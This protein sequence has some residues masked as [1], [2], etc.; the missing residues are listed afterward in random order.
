M[1]VE[2]LS[3]WGDLTQEDTNRLGVFRPERVMA[4][5]ATAEIPRELKNNEHARARLAQLRR[6]ASGLEHTAARQATV[7]AIPVPE[8]AGIVPVQQPMPAPLAPAYPAPAPAP[9]APAFS[10]APAPAPVAPAPAFAPAPATPAPGVPTSEP[11]NIPPAPTP[12]MIPQPALPVS[13][14]I[15][16]SRTPWQSDFADAG[17]STEAAI[18]AAAAAFWARPEL[19]NTLSERSLAPAP[20]PASDGA[21]RAGPGHA[22]GACVPS[23][24]AGATDTD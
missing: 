2:V 23:A 17:K 1:V 12:E 9:V 15:P 21:V 6:W 22:S 20:A 24:G 14:A 7:A 19:G 10:Y 16:L 5:V 18:A 11:F 3:G 8:Y 4:A 13:S